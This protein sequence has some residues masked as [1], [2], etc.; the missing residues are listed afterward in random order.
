MEVTDRHC[1]M[2]QA[3]RVALR[4][5]WLYVIQCGPEQ[6]CGDG[7]EVVKASAVIFKVLVGSG[8]RVVRAFD[9]RMVVVY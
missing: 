3:Y 1:A 4:S 2:E 9:V 6:G 8:T 5:R 7:P